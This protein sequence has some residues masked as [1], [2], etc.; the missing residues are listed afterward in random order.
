MKLDDFIFY[1]YLS[2]MI[3]ILIAMF[4]GLIIL[5]I[6]QYSN[7]KQDEILKLEDFTY[8]LQSKTDKELVAIEERYI[9]YLTDLYLMDS[10][11]KWYK[12]IDAIQK[13]MEQRSEREQQR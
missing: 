3:P 13:H 8:R 5:G 4:I 12:Y 2:F 1:S 10:S 11:E 9:G 7:A 6:S